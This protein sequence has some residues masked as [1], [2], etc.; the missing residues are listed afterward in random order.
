MQ[1]KNGDLI[2]DD[3]AVWIQGRFS[4]LLSTL[5]STI[6]QKEEWLEAAKSG[7]NFLLKHPLRI[8]KFSIFKSGLIIQ[9]SASNKY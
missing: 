9:T 8:C 5:Y 3:K 6:E 1:N 2:D 4:W 7:V